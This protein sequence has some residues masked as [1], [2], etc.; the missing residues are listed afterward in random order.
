MVD[1]VWHYGHLI[2]NKVIRG[3]CMNV[4]IET[5]RL[6]LKNYNE[7]DLG[8]IRKL[9]SDPMVWKFS[10][11]V[12][13]TKLGDAKIHLES[14]LKNYAEN[15]CDFQSLF[16]KDTGEYIGEAGILSSN[17][18]NNRS[19]LGYNLL[20]RFWANGYA[21][22]IT[23][24]LVKHLFEVEKVER[25]E[26]L[27]GDG[28]GASRKVLEKAGFIQEGLL[29]NFAYIDNRYINVYYY[30]IIKHDYIV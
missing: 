20:H 14:V 13:T 25:I 21:T 28:N 1:E 2:Q 30:G 17:K 12:S 23:K 22:E 9:K 16:L 19:V 24:A 4:Q 18:Q 3:S 10:T 27:V 5:A 29:R 11:K 8:N 26:A 7:N 15:K 6:I